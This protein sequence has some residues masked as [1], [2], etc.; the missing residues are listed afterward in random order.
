MKTL[1]W[2]AAGGLGLYILDQMGYL[3]T[4]A[5]ATTTAPA[6]SSSP[7]ANTSTSASTTTAAS[8]NNAPTLAQVQA[9]L[10]NAAASDANFSQDSQGNWTA[11]SAY[12]WSYYVNSIV[13]ATANM[14]LSAIF[15]GV[16]LTQPMGWTYFWNGMGPYLT[17]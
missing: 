1:L 10:L 16:D 15:P 12:H 14:N 11:N 17:K 3:G 8:T 4:T 6:T 9:Y 2:L 7:Q 13:P 5:T